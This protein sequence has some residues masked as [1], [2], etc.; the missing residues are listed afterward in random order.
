MDALAAE[1]AP[2]PAVRRRLPRRVPATLVCGALLLLAIVTLAAV[3]PWIAPYPYDEM[4]IMARLKPLSA[5][6]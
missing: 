5:A 1:A 6:Q 3:A 2:P 4:N